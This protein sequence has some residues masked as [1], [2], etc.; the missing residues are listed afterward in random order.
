M[1]KR[2]EREGGGKGKK[3]NKSDKFMRKIAVH[4]ACVK[5]LGTSFI[6]DRQ[7]LKRLI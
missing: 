2:R 1:E 5:M 6:I 3:R 4:R 7:I